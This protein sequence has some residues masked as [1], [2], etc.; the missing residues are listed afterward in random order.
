MGEGQ[1]YTNLTSFLSQLQNLGLYNQGDDFYG[2]SNLEGGDIANQM[3][4][5]FDVPSASGASGLYSPL[6]EGLLKGASITNYSP[7]IQSSQQQAVGDL[8]KAYRSPMARKAYGKGFAGTGATDVYGKQIKSDYTK[9]LTD[10]LTNVYGQKGKS[11]LALS[12][13]VQDLI[14]NTQGLMGQ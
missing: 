4:Q 9:K 10:T 8:S 11:E 2:L 1:G 12:D 7:Q 3:S 13:W 6:S 14:K 5:Y